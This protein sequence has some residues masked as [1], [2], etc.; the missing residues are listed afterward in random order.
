MNKTINGKVFEFNIPTLA[1][2]ENVERLDN[3][4]FYVLKHFKARYMWRKFCRLAFKMNFTWKR[5]HIPPRELWYKNVKLEDF[6][7]LQADFFGY[8]GEKQK[9]ANKLMLP[10]Q[11]LKPKNLG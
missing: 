11:D 1:V 2:Q 9:E 5:L 6:G 3:K 8:V 4:P 10:L 7:G